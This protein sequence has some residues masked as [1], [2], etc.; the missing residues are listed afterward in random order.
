MSDS[1]KK[2]KL[3]KMLVQ[4][5]FV[6]ED[7]NGDIEEVRYADGSTNH[8]VV[9]VGKKEWENYPAVMQQQIEDW[10]QKLDNPEPPPN[11]ATRRKAAKRTTKKAAAK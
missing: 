11:R 2:V 3:V 4:P 6:Y 5:V 10:Q 8:P 1:M 7:E 9:E